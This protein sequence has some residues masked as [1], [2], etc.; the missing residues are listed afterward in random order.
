MRLRSA[1]GSLLNQKS[2]LIVEDNCFLALD[3]AMAVEDAGGRVVGPVASV[4]DALSLLETH[5]LGGAVLDCQLTDRDVTPVVMELIDRG[6]PLVIHTG[7]GLPPALSEAH[8]N[9]PVLMKPLKPAIVVELLA[10]RMRDKD[11]LQING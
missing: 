6:V 11:H 2:I 7:T 8:P 4:A 9:L 5:Q 10:S 3:L 1:G